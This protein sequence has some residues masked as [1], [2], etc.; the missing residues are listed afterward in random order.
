MFV[1]RAAR[2]MDALSSRHVLEPYDIFFDA[3]GTRQLDASELRERQPDNESAGSFE[4]TAFRLLFGSDAVSS[5]DVRSRFLLCHRPWRG[6]D[7]WTRKA[8]YAHRPTE[9]VILH[10]DS[11]SA[12]RQH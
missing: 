4:A 8:V 6:R 11:N 1:I 2:A 12:P 10:H 5:I 9:L 7:D 3:P